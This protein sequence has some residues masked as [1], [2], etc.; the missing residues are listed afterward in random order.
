[1]ILSYTVQNIENYSMH[2][3]YDMKDKTMKKKF[4]KNLIFPTRAYLG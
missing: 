3:T 1:M 4:E 2:G